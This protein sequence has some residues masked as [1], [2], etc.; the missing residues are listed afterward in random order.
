[1]PS[2]AIASR[3]GIKIMVSDAARAGDSDN[4]YGACTTPTQE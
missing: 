4:V 2:V 1:M 3:A